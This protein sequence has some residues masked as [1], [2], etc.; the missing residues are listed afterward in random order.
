LELAVNV[1]TVLLQTVHVRIVI[2]DVQHAIDLVLP[3]QLH[4]SS[5][6]AHEQAVQ[7]ANSDVSLL[8]ADRLSVPRCKISKNLGAAARRELDQVLIWLLH[9]FDAPNSKSHQR[10]ELFLGGLQSANRSLLLDAVVVKAFLQRVLCF[11]YIPLIG[12]IAE[13]FLDRFRRHVLGCP[14]S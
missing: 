8:D 5:L 14:E 3:L 9:I 10:Q 13:K 4:L 11:A 12:A 1:S 6:E 2:E 7:A